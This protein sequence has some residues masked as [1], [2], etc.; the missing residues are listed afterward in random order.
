MANLKVGYIGLSDPC[1]M[2]VLTDA[3]TMAFF[4]NPDQMGRPHGT[5]PNPAAVAGVMIPTP[6]FICGVKLQKQIAVT[7]NFI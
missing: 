6:P 7:C 3:Q 2:M 1:V 5:I 4:E